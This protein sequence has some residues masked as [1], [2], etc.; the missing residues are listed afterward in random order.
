MESM[1]EDFKFPIEKAR[2]FYNTFLPFSLA[3]NEI[4][5]KYTELQKTFENEFKMRGIDL[6]SNI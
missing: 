5:K 4:S 3:I 1:L 6:S 2:Q